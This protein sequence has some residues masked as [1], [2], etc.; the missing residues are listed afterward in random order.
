MKLQIYNTCSFE[1]LA[2]QRSCKPQVKGSSPFRGLNYT[3]N[4]P[5]AGFEPALPKREPG[6]KPGALDRSAISA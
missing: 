3:K 6:L 5:R 1:Q 4:S 2:E